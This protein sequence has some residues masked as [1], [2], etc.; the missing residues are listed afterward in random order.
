M[1]MNLNLIPTPTLEAEQFSVPPFQGQ[2]QPMQQPMP[3]QPMQQPQGLLGRIGAGIKRSVQDPDFMDRLTI[4]LG[5]MTMRPNEALM[6]L[7]QN[8]IEQRQKLGMANATARSVVAR[9]RAEGKDQMADMI[10]QNP[11]MASAYLKEMIKSQLSTG[12]KKETSPLQYDDFTGQAFYVQIGQDGKPVR[13]NVEGAVA[14]T[15]DVVAKRQT[16]QKLT[17]FDVKRAQDMA[18]DVFAQSKTI[19]S[20][21][22]KLYR[23]K[24]LVIEGGARTGIINQ[25]LPSFNAATAELR[26][27]ASSLGIDII[28][29]ATFGALSE[30][31]LTLALSTGFDQSLQGQELVD[32]IES[33]LA[34]QTKL[35]N[36][37]LDDA[38]LLSSGIGYQEYI[39]MRT[40][41]PRTT[42]IP[43]FRSLS[44]DDMDSIYG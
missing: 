32:Y 38:K 22:S 17:E 28:N 44:D 18:A 40:S 35:R 6:G 4:G 26:G 14:E 20:T 39:Q 3:E 34:A 27:L 10:E 1:A 24:D 23:I 41:E 9:L 2:Q 16:A 43:D 30:K 13:I 31:E 5:G 11:S 7:A 21:M 19:D 15:P 42:S 33:K 37:L 29:S 8:R 12:F 25:Y 36:Q